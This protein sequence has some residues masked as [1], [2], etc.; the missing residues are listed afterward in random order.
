MKVTL[1]I[2][3]QELAVIEDALAANKVSVEATQKWCGK[4]EAYRICE[5]KLKDIES[6]RRKLN[7]L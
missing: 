1:E 2:T 7:E 5:K 6:L 3:I 4:G